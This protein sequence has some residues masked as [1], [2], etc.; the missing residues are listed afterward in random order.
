MGPLQ[1]LPHRLMGS[2]QGAY[3]QVLL[4]KKKIGRN[5]HSLSFVVPLFVPLVIT[6]C[7]T[8]CHSLSLVVPLVVIRCHS[9]HHSLPFVATRCITRLS[10]CK[11]SFCKYSALRNFANFTGKQ[12]FEISFFDR[13]VP[14]AL[15]K[16]DSN[17]SVL[18]WNLQIF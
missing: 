13:V 1:V 14:A 5:N 12:L 2:L 4:E 18:L 3:Q 15:S 17:T 7:T 8:R 10:F 9:L 6:C 16:R 11:R